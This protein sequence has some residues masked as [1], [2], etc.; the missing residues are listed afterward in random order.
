MAEQTFRSPGFFD[1]EIEVNQQV[2][3]ATITTT[4]AGIIGTAEKGPAFIP[5]TVNT[6][7]D[8]K[9]KFGGLDPN[10]FGPFAVRE[11]LKNRDAA[12][13]LRVL[14]AGSNVNA[15]DINLTKNYGVVKNAGF[16]VTHA[17]AAGAGGKFQVG[18]ANFLVAKHFVSSSEAYGYP[19]F[20]QNESFTASSGVKL[21]RAIIFAASDARVGLMSYNSGASDAISEAGALAGTP[22][23]ATITG[24]S[25]F[26]SSPA[27]KNRFKIFVSSSDSTTLGNA[28]GIPGMRIFTASLDPR[29]QNYIRNVLNTN[30]DNFS[31]EKHLLYACFDVEPELASVHTGPSSIG[32]MSG[33]Q[34]TAAAGGS[35]AL[36]A[37]GRF[38]TRY[39][40]AQTTMFISQ[41]YGGTEYDLFHFEA[42]DDGAYP[43]GKYKISIAKL[44]ASTDE[45]NPYGTFSVQVRAFDDTDSNPQIIEEY[46]ECDLNPASERFVGRQVGDRKA[47][48]NFDALDDV[49]KKIVTSG[50][51]ANRSNIV[52]IV[53]SDALVQNQIP[54]TSLPFGFKGLPAL[55][56]NPRFA[57]NK[58]LVR[59]NA[60]LTFNTSSIADLDPTDIRCSLTASIMPPVPLVFKVTDG[61]VA[62][63]EVEF[64]GEAGSLE[65]ANRKYYWGVKTTRIPADKAIRGSA[66]ILSGVL[67][68]NASSELNLGLRDMTKLIGIGKQGALLTGS[69]ADLQSNNKFTLAKVALGT[70][71]GSGNDALYN[72]TELASSGTIDEIMANA[73]YVR[74][75]SPRLGSYTI[76]D[77]TM[78]NRISFGTLVS[79]TSSV[80]FNKFTD[81]LKFTNVLYG[82]YDG[83]NI[84]DRNARFLNDKSTSLDANGGANSSFTSP[85][86]G[87]NV[88]GSGK[89]NSG[90][91]SYRTAIDIMTDP[92]AVNT[93]IL[94]VPGIRESFVTDHALTKNR[95][96][97]M[98]LYLMDI[99]EYDSDANRLYDD[100]SNSPS[101]GETSAQF[102]T[103]AVDN[104][105]AATYF[106]SI[107]L[108]DTEGANVTV[109]PSVAAL[110][111]LGFNDRVS[112]PWFAPAGFNRGSL[113]F[114]EAV[115]TR[116]TTDDRNTLYDTR[117]NPIASFPRQGFVIF[118]QKTL[119]VARS[120]LDRVN[121][122]RL[123]LEVRRAV[124]QVANTFVFEQN[125]PALRAKFVAQVTPLLAVIQ[126]QSGI[127]Q[128]RVVM[129]DTNNAQEDIE[130]NRLNGK[131]V[132]VPTRTVEFISM[133]F[134]ITNAGVSFE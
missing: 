116:L 66:G 49:E 124:S 77:G 130:S 56:T 73:A 25:E 126:S 96:Y 8:F 100:S 132:I 7:D 110:A 115:K 111:A 108:S 112:F 27:M 61:A 75:A 47:V 60:R 55:N 41:P 31:K 24:S 12:T 15:G 48:F 63:D 57:D 11:F 121:V 46:P 58:V 119:Q 70:Q 51:Y 3:P 120:A 128:F 20:S 37:F 81:Y 84:L 42:L 93:N 16:K 109:P 33:S 13:Y 18:G 76:D 44:R 53:L 6:F 123:L 14:G 26:P 5:I 83:V 118:G 69:A 65:A 23:F 122:R 95:D 1:Q 106:P 17:A 50:K 52:R 129:D 117:I 10:R 101:V 59:E 67:K 71:A 28:D 94:A 99:P 131:I 102:Q 39:Q 64:V 2:E 80:T 104:N 54:K 88:A 113:D 90:V 107:V 36:D 87:S 134:V 74:N 98:S 30:P 114:V 29:D 89:D 85:G 22:Y 82:G 127:D 72:D 105:S 125:T 38:D 92:F 45:N 86:L 40:T 79:Q 78:E 19:I 4:P 21:V 35:S 62:D 9:A 43:N 32:L 91:R 68:S 133:D 103:R 34:V 97:G